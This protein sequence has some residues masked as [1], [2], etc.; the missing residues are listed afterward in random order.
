MIV[1]MLVP[2]CRIVWPIGFV[3]LEIVGIFRWFI[4]LGI[5]KESLKASAFN[6]DGGLYLFIGFFSTLF[7][8][9]FPYM[10]VLDCLVFLLWIS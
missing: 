10:E 5:Y 2:R 1:R 6:G 4:S 3:P 9:P 8:V 7:E